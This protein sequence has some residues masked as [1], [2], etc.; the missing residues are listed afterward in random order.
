MF[1]P[2]P[3]DWDAIDLPPALS[4][5]YR[6]VR[7]VRLALDRSGLRRRDQAPLEPFLATPQSLIAP[8]LEFGEVRATDVVADVG[9]GDGRI[10]IEAARTIGCRAIGIEQ[11]PQLAALA[12]E[13]ADSAGVADRVSIVDGDARNIDVG[14]VDVVLLFLPMVVAVRLVP[15]LLQRLSPGARVILHEQ[16]PLAAGLPS[17]AATRALVSEDGVTVAHVWRVEN[18]DLDGAGPTTNP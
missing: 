4:W 10:V 9:C 14:Q 11:S 12:R 18:T 6:L 13:S 8:L 17:P 3:P 16:S 15:N 5:L 1:R 2:R 7:P